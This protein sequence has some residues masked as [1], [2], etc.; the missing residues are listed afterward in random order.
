MVTVFEPDTPAF[1][2]QLPQFQKAC[3]ALSRRM[4]TTI[5]PEE[6][7][8]MVVGDGEYGFEYMAALI[9]ITRRMLRARVDSWE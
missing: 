9:S 1:A 2:S 7:A 3:R 8:R 5:E 4:K 6:V